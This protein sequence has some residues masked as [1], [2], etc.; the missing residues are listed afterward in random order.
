MAQRSFPT[1]EI[2]GSNPVISKFYSQ[3][4]VLKVG[5]KDENKEKEAWNGPVKKLL[6][7]S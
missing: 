3:S 6:Y 2:R 7:V 5:I 1:P 4:T